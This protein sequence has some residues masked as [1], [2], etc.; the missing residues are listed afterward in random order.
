M[1][2]IWCYGGK[3]TLAEAWDAAKEFQKKMSN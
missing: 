2:K 1:Q 3:R